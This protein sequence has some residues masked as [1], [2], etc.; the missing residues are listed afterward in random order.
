MRVALWFLLLGVSLAWGH[1]LNVLVEEEGAELVVWAYF[2]KDSPCME[3]QVVLKNAQGMIERELLTDA[4]G[5]ARLTPLSSGALELIVN[6]GAGH[7]K[8]VTFSYA[9]PPQEAQEREGVLDAPLVLV[10]PEAEV[11]L[12]GIAQGVALLLLFFGA[13]WW[14]YR[15]RR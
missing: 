2:K 14:V 5:Y 1:R 6:G 12:G 4:L 11:S 10:R 7:Q 13:L 15:R 8:S 3:C 9:P